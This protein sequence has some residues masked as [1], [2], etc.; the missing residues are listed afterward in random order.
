MRDKPELTLL[1]GISTDIVIIERA[2]ESTDK[3]GMSRATVVT[4]EK[5]HP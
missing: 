1:S 4:P 3:K 5:S 2:G